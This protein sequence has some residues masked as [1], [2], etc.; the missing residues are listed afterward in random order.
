MEKRFLLHLLYIALIDIRARSC[1]NGDNVTFGLCDLL[2]NTPPMLSTDDDVLVAYNRLL[3]KVEARGLSHWL[4]TRREE[5]YQ[6][7]PEYKKD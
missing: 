2:H 4:Q 5:F 6:R 1:E 3:E 7:Y